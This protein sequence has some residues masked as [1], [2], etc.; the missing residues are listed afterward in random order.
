MSLESLKS[1]RS[2]I[3]GIVLVLFIRLF[4]TSSIEDLKSY[5]ET[6]FSFNTEEAIKMILVIVIGF[7]Y[8]SFKLRR[9]LFE[10]YLAIVQQNIKKRIL[11]I[12]N[13]KEKISFTEAKNFINTNKGMILFYYIIDNDNSL[14][15]K[16]KIVKYNGLIWTTLTDISIFSLFFLFLEFYKVIKFKDIYFSYVSIIFAVIGIIC[17][18]LN[19]IAVRNHIKLSNEQ[20]DVIEQIYA[21]KLY[22]KYKN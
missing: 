16:S 19:H 5:I 17:L 11:L 6:L 7:F 15:E 4:N 13:S 22:E 1:L 12:I 9:I 18:V 21:D 10:P 2:Y 20:L 14:T 3:P 8:N